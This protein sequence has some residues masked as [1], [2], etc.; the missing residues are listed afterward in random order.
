MASFN[1]TIPGID[2]TCKGLS[3]RFNQ[4][5]RYR[6]LIHHNLPQP[7]KEDEDGFLT[8]V[9][10]K[11]EIEGSTTHGQTTE[12]PKST[13]LIVTQPKHSFVICADSQVGMTSLNLEWETEL[14][15]CRKAVETINSLQPRPEFVTM[16]GDI[17]DME[18]SFYYN[19]PKALRKFETL[20]ECNAIQDKQNED[21]KK[22]FNSIHEDIGIVC[23]CGNHDIGNRPNKTSIERFRNSFGDEYL[24]FWTNG[25]YNI[26]LN[27]VLFTN[28]TG[29]MEMYNDQLKWLEDRLQYAA[30]LRAVQI[31][32]FGHHPWFLYNEKEDIQDL[33]DE[34]SPFPKEWGESSEIFPDSYFSVPIKY[35]M[36]AM[37]LFEK[38]K[39]S[40]C[41][42][43]HFHQNLV[44]KA[45]FGM[46]MII[47]A[48]LSIVFESSGKPRQTEQNDRGIRIVEVQPFCGDASNQKSRR[49]L[50]CGSFTHHFEMI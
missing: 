14:N 19:N 5:Q 48:P 22:V 10:V 38:Y 26:C 29:A 7:S 16:C 28:P 20:E 33:G 40:A 2:E 42:S 3:R 21:F 8:G 32:I 18:Q 35:R 12:L 41:F 47:T 36:A 43:G 31:F 6:T 23:L 25:S 11:G 30:M 1:N 39:V 49:E 45:S 46:D 34:G 44:S 4:A 9:M 50:G 27:N 17:V 24:A 15:F 13:E 37:E